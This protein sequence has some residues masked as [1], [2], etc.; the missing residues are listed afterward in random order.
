MSISRVAA[1]LLLIAASAAA[2]PQVARA[3]F[4]GLDLKL[5][6]KCDTGWVLAYIKERFDGKVRAYLDS[7]LFITRIHDP[8][9]RYARLRDD[10]H[11]V[12]RQYCQAK[13]EMTDRKIR[14]IFY[15]LEYPWGFSGQLTHIEFC[16]PGMDPNR[17]YGRL[18][19][20]V[21]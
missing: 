9:L 5:E 12:G 16:I 11:R 7:K 10:E 19:S 6:D 2:Q 18:C 4:L 20:T 1:S 15:T 21:R 3:D 13:V 14:D 17:V 8:V